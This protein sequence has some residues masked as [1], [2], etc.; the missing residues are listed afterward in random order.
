VVVIHNTNQAV[1]LAEALLTAGI[2]AIEVTLRTECALRAIENIATT[3]P[4]MILG[5][6]SV[7]RAGQF[8]E[9]EGA[10]GTYRNAGNKP[11]AA[12]R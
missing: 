2:N 12:N 8:A 4:E 1:P 11:R 6:G 10:G 5:A 9:V 7:R 3:L